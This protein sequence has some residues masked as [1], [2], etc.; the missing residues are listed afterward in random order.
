M[1]IAYVEGDERV[2]LLLSFGEEKK[3]DFSI[4]PQQAGQ[5]GVRVI[6]RVAGQINT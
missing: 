4:K 1:A 3:D 6:Y 5:A 2:D